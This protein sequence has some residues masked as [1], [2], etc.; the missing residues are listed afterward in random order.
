MTSDFRGH[1]NWKLGF[2]FGGKWRLIRSLEV[3]PEEKFCEE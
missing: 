3:S 1:F 2:T